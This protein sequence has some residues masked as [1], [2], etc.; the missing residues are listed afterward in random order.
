M[1]YETRRPYRQ[2]ARAEAAEATARRILDV[3]AAAIRERW[4]DEVRLEDIARD[5][6]VSVQTVIR[7]FGSKEGLLEGLAEH[8]GDEVRQRRSVAPGDVAAAA[9][10]LSDDYDASGDMVM[11]L[12]SQE[13]RYPA[14]RAIADIGRAGHRAWVAAIFAA[15]LAAERE[16]E[17]TLDALVVATDLYV[18]KLYRRDMRRGADDYRAA[19]EAMVRAVLAR[20]R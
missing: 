1:N 3:F 6:G 18:W 15:A 4:F 14:I 9:A 12:L 13:D 7:R 8:I 5:A 2:T 17:R 16:P 19:V 20:S 10:A 11:R